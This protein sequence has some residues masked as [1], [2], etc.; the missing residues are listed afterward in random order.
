MHLT[1]FWRRCRLLVT[2]SAAL[3]CMAGEARAQRPT[4]AALAS[5]GTDSICVERFLAALQ[6]AL[7][8]D[9]SVAV[10]KLFQYPPLG[11]PYL[12]RLQLN[13]RR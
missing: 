2:V 3:A 5:S 1:S 12:A 9:D 6:S 11:A 13:F 4:A 7:S 10:S 8:R